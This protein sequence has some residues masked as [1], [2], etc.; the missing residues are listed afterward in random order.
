MSNI[1][2]AFSKPEVAAG[3]KKN[4]DTEWVFR[5]G[6]LY[7]RRTGTGKRKQSGVWNTG[8]RMPVYGY[9]VYGNSRLSATGV[10]DASDRFPGFHSG[11]RGK[12]SGL[13]FHANESA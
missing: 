13:S 9:D 6:S 10:S 3:I 2:I 4:I 1:V 11:E 7:H 8:L 12:Q 5:A